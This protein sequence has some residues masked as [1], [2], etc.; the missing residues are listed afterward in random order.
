MPKIGL[1]LW[2]VRDAIEEDF[3]GTVRRVAAMGYAGVE[4]AFFPEHV[5]FRQ[6][7]QLFQSLGLKVAGIHCEI[8]DS[9]EEKETW[10]EMAEAYDCDRMVWHGWP[11][12]NRYHSVTDTTRWIEIYGEANV[13]AKAH[14]LRFGLHNHWWEFEDHAGHT[15]FYY[16]LEHLPED[17]FFEID[18]YWAKT[19]GQD[20]ATVV[21]DF[22]ERAPLLHIKDGP[23]PAGQVINEQVVLGQ[24]SL[25]IPA[26][27]Q[28]SGDASEW[29]IVEFDACATDVIR[30]VAES[31]RYLSGTG[32]GTGAK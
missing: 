9:D 8:P 20:P 11:R 32:L 2:S 1:Q 17:V 27:V 6:A 24:G 5:T 28:A 29:L 7:G 25:D 21:A 15:P 13:F 18:T 16:M 23:A 30:A 14:G 12:D 10:L 19:G 31:Y 26:I 3:E 4:T 22:G